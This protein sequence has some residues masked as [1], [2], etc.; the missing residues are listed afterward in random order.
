MPST[1]EHQALVRLLRLLAERSYSFTTPNNGTIRRS[2]RIAPPGPRSLR[3][4]FGWNLPFGEGDLDSE[5]REALE[6]AGGLE[7]IAEGF[8]SR[9]RASSVEGLLFLHS[10]YPTTDADS[11]F[12]GPDSYRFAR[13]IG[14][15]LAEKPVQG[16]ILDIGT[17]AGVGGLVAA[18]RSPE[19]GIV[20]TD[21]NPRALGLAAANAEHAG[22]P[23]TL[24][25]GRGLTPASGQFDL[26]LAN[27]PF[28]AGE[29]GVAY[30][31]GGDLHGARL[32]LD[33]AMDSLERLTPGGRLVLYTG[34]PIL[35]GGEDRFG[36][37]LAEAVK[38][39]AFRLDYSEIDPDIFPG[40][41][42]REA[43]EDV[44][45]IAAVAAI[46]SRPR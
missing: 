15:V 38:A 18:A 37:L 43:Y 39:A 35:K 29:S 31:D 11:V 33:W 34:S 22:L 21:P 23:V 32:S 42:G 9:L 28:I 27:P 4:V 2:R 7:T 6:A 41:L 3:D 16:R 30:K 36:R 45:R 19:C 40:E 10:A 1:F 5:L 25:E 12:L 8:R 46:V 44:E 13:L 14:Q 24:C 26:I 17:G 20:L